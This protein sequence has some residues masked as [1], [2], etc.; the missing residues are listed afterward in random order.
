[1]C[2]GA[3]PGILERGRGRGRSGLGRIDIRV[4]LLLFF[5]S[6]FL[7]GSTPARAE[8]PEEPSGQRFGD[9]LIVSQ[10]VP[11]VWRHVSFRTEPGG[12]RTQA[13]GLLVTTG[14]MSLLIDTGWRPDQ[15][16]RLLD[17]ADKTLGQPVEHVIVTGSHPDR[18]G[19]LEAV[20][21]RPII[22][23]GHA[24][25]A[26]LL[27]KSGRPQLHWTFE[28]E[29]RLDLGGEAIH[30]FYPGPGHTPDN[31]VVW[32]PRRKVLFTGCLALCASARDLGDLQ[33]ADLARWP[34]AVRRVIDNYRD[35][36]VL[37]PGHGRPG[38]VELLSHTMELLEQA[39]RR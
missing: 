14:E 19:G 25:T 27:R 17:W 21:A 26:E 37:V 18:C 10:L 34:V 6:P 11:G 13:N 36:E 2:G 39:T 8:E 5:L 24:L 12:A 22:V 28:F 3:G 9:D 15:T 29:E 20:L 1:M 23:H 16:R 38:G 33:D 30:L 31:I 35:A 4:W 7:L 32:L